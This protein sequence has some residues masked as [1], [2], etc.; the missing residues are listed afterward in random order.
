MPATITLFRPV[1]VREL[2]LILGA[3]SRAFPPRLPEQPI[4]YPVLNFE[5][6]DQIAREWN[7][8]SLHQAGYVT[9]FEVD[10]A[11][12]SRFEAKQVGARMHRELWVPAEELGE[13]NRH[14]VGA[15]RVVS[16]HFGP[17]FEGC[18]PASGALQGLHATAQLA[19]LGGLLERNRT[20]FVRELGAQPIAVRLNYPFWC[21]LPMEGKDRVLTAVAAAWRERYPDDALSVT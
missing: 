13:F 5:Y 19:T 11:Y 18:I 8:P 20:E 17:A 21:T 4:F 9:R 16:A 15:I 7:A 3:E 12:G 6:A 2:E 1:G 10:A 14:I